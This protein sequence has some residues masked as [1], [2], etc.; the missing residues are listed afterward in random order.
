M[1]SENSRQSEDILTIKEVAAS[2][3][4]SEATVLRWLKA[5][6]IEGFF[7]LGRRWLI[8]KTDFDEL[9]NN[10]AVNEHVK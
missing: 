3:R 7:R 9:I 2:L 4:I 6:K 5:K 1:G 8:R 10:R